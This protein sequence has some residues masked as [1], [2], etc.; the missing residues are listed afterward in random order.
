MITRPCIWCSWGEYSISFWHVYLNIILIYCLLKNVLFL[1]FEVIFHVS[2][3]G[4]NYFKAFFQGRHFWQEKRA[5]QMLQNEYFW[6]LFVCF[7]VSCRVDLFLFLEIENKVLQCS[8]EN[9]EAFPLTLSSLLGHAGAS[10]CP[11]VKM[12]KLQEL[13]RYQAQSFNAI[14]LRKLKVLTSDHSE[15]PMWKVKIRSAGHTQMNKHF[16]E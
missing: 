12:E 5:M 7:L 4:D 14:F 11:T 2:L 8:S 9:A 1:T 10:P 15:R 16:W 3:V 6:M 13:K